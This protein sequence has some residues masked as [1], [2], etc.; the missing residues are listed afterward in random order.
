MS[1]AIVKDVPPV[2]LARQSRAILVERI[3]GLRERLAQVHAQSEPAR[4]AVALVGRLDAQRAAMLADGL[5]SGSM[6]DLDVLDQQ[7][8]AARVEAATAATMVT[9]ADAVEA[10]LQQ[11]ID[12][13]H[14]LLPQRELAIRQAV[15]DGAVGEIEAQARKVRAAANALADELGTLTGMGVA[16][17]EMA[18]EMRRQGVSCQALGSETP[19]LAHNI[20]VV[21]FGFIDGGV[22]NA[23]RIEHRVETMQ[24]RAAALARWK[25]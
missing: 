19:T 17:Q 8:A 16:H 13:L 3:A 1:L 15:F 21:G 10:E 18:A 25:A 22:H 2:E 6:P 9:A 7:R 14:R 23:L 24:A 12:E 5:R 20:G 11:D 4:E